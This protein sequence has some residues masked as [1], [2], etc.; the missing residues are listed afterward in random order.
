M[1]MPLYFTESPST[2]P[3]IENLMLPSYFVILQ[4]IAENNQS[5]RDYFIRQY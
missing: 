3:E 1:Q 4:F 5:Y 2:E